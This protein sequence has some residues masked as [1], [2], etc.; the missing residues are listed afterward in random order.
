MGPLS[1]PAGAQMP[2]THPS[3]DVWLYH[4]DKT[5]HPLFSCKCCI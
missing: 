3:S 4:N 2:C 1:D 5:A